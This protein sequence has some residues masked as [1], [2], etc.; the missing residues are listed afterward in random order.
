MR[1][2]RTPRP[3]RR[4]KNDAEAQFFDAASAAGWEAWKRGWPDFFLVRGGEIAV[5][6]VKPETDAALSR[7]QR[8]VLFALAS[9]GVPC[10]VWRPLRGF[11][12]IRPRVP[13][14]P[15]PDPPFARWLPDL[16]VEVDED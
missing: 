15:V 6:E 5:V 11:V 13:P 9:Y 10:Y 7:Q 1:R 14:A 3:P 8:T 16:E 2:N 12:R 4:P